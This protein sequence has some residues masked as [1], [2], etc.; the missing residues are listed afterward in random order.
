MRS[1]I[2]RRLLFASL[3]VFA[4]A[5]AVAAQT[6]IKVNDAT[7]STVDP[8]PKGGASC[9]Y[10]VRPGAIA[11][12]AEQASGRLTVS[13][14][15]AR[16]GW[17]I[18]T[19]VPWISTATSSQISGYAQAVVAD[20]PAG[21]WRLDD[22]AGSIVITDASGSGHAGAVSG[23]VTFGETAALGDGSTTASFDGGTGTVTIPNNSGFDLPTLTWEAW[24]K[25][26]SVS[27]SLRRIFGKSGTR[28]DG[29]SLW[30]EPISSQAELFF[31]AAGRGRVAVTLHTTV[32]GAG[33][34]HLAFTYGGG[35][36]HASVN[37]IEDQSGAASGT[38]GQQYKPDRHGP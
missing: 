33:W 18:T 9:T 20:H 11:A 4:C 14:G 27:S 22:P 24:V 31:G 28:D 21:Y 3:M 17:T 2:G 37:G 15:D 23:G 32:V 1:M 38:V 29:F 8:L 30:V 12:A 6:H 35:T 26:P 25:I 10:N 36:W 13:A 34:V 16:C 19:S 7:T 5:G